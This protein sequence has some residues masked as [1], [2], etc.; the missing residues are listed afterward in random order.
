[1][2]QVVSEPDIGRCVSLLTV[3]RRG[4]DTRWCASKDSGPKG[5]GFGGGPTS[6]GERNECHKD[7]G[8][9]KG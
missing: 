2:L 3:S 6:T 8:L 7:V 1:M 5:G 4:V 9:E